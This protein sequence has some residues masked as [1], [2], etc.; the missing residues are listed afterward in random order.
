VF[1]AWMA[2]LRA[3]PGSVLWGLRCVCVRA[4]VQCARARACMSLI[5]MRELR[6]ESGIRDER[7]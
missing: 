5:L 6:N 3:D 1:E 4:F 2:I 7:S